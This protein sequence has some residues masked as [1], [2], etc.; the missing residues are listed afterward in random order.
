MT[1]RF[2]LSDY[3][4][5]L[6]DTSQKVPHVTYGVLCSLS[7]ESVPQW[8]M[9]WK[10]E[11]SACPGLGNS[12]STLIT[13]RPSKMACEAQLSPH[14]G[15]NARGHGKLTRDC[16]LQRPVD[17]AT[18]KYTFRILQIVDSSSVLVNRVEVDRVKN[19]FHGIVGG[20]CRAIY[21]CSP[22]LC[23]LHFWL[24]TARDHKSR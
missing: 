2:L 4:S 5:M 9:P 16:A 10:L 15:R 22:N 12:E 17:N 13:T 19:G 14:L 21:M 6:S 8:L 18:T 24:S 7:A 11:E 3:S 23:K 1:G 20:C